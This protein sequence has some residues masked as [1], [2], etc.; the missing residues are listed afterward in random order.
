MVTATSVRC[1]GRQISATRLWF[2]IAC[3]ES[4]YDACAD[5]EVVLVVVAA[6][7]NGGLQV[8]GC[9]QADCEAAA[10]FEVES[11]ADVCGEGRAGVG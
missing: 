7:V 10:G 9:N 5:A 6:V 2:P 11:S 8:V 3:S 1:I 4:H